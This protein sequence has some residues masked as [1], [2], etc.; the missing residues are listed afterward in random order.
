MAPIATSK[1]EGLNRTL[2]R[3]FIAVAVL[4]AGLAFTGCK[5]ESKPPEQEEM[6]QATDKIEMRVK[7]G[8][9]IVIN[10]QELR[11]HTVDK[12]GISLSA[13]G[14]AEDGL[15]PVVSQFIGHKKQKSTLVA[16]ISFEAG[17]KLLDGTAILIITPTQP[18]ESSRSKS[19]KNNEALAPVVIV[20]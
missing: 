11:V 17:R 9:N 10:G 20:P 19:P 18:A 1:T 7:E 2:R 8:D 15:I 14:P 3:G 12:E 4:A 13:E 6:S 16:G 5:K